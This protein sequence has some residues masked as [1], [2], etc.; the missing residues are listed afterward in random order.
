MFLVM[1]FYALFVAGRL[2]GLLYR[3]SWTKLKWLEE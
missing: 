2:L 1:G 3:T